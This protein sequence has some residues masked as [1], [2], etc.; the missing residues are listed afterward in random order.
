M[1]KEERDR[2]G[3]DRE[4]GAQPAPAPGSRPSLPRPRT[5]WPPAPPHPLPLPSPPPPPSRLQSG[6]PD[7]DAALRRVEDSRAAM[8]EVVAAIAISEGAGASGA[9][10]A[11]ANVLMT[12]LEAPD[13]APVPAEGPA[14]PDSH[15]E[16]AVEQMGLSEAQVGRGAAAGLWAL[17]VA[18]GR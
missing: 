1:T 2:E 3:R 4:G 9:P 15:W 10:S 11:F 8:L 13:G 18:Q 5:P 14:V 12:S 17:V 6:A 7:A 16:W